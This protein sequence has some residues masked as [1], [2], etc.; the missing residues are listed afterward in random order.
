M[1]NPVSGASLTI[2]L[3]PSHTPQYGTRRRFSL[4]HNLCP[5]YATSEHM[6]I[7]GS[8]ADRVSHSLHFVSLV[9]GVTNP[10]LPV[11]IVKKHDNR[12]RTS[13]CKALSHCRTVGFRDRE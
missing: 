7:K 1:S 6:L 9:A 8:S 3:P 2:T 5:G 12:S 4:R 11:A 13:A 10:V